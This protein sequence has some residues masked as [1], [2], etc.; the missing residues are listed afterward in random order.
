MVKPKRP[1]NSQRSELL[2]FIYIFLLRKGE[3]WGNGR[4]VGGNGG[5][6]VGGGKRVVTWMGGNGGGRE[7]KGKGGVDGVFGEDD[8]CV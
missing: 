2:H 6:R 1:N 5:K 8:Q 7:G 3:G 4:V